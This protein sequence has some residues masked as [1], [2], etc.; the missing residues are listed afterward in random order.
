MQLTYLNTAQIADILA[1][2]KELSRLEADGITTHV[3]ESAYGRDI[4]L[5]VSNLHGT[6]QMLDPC[7]YDS[8]AGGSV[9]DH[10]RASLENA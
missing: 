4:L 1:E 7:A 9:H 10:A 5:I 8:D 2:S 3:L 6:G